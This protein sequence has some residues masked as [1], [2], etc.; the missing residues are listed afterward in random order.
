MLTLPSMCVMT[1]R[2]RTHVQD[3]TLY[4][5]SNICL[6]WVAAAEPTLAKYPGSGI[7]QVEKQ[8]TAF[9]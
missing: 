2:M 8:S 9:N 5:T 4:E 1:C 3:F 6:S 7:P